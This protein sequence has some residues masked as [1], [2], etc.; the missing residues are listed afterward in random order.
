MARIK[1]FWRIVLGFIIF[2]F[3]VY[4]TGNLVFSGSYF[5]FSFWWAFFAAYVFLAVKIKYDDP[6]RSMRDLIAEQAAQGNARKQEDADARE[7]ISKLEA[8]LAAMKDRLA[9]RD[10]L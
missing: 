7:K 8:E 10:D 4:H 5:A 3:C 1:P 9:D 2:C 6:L